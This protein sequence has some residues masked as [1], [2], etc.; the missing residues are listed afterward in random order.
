MRI[1]PTGKILGANIEDIDLSQPLS[2]QR[3]QADPARARRARRPLLPEAASGGGGLRPLRRH[4]RRARDQRRQ[5]VPRAGP[6]AGHG[7]LQH[8]QGRQAGRARRCRP[9]LAHRHVLF[10]RTS[11][12]PTCSTPSRCRCA[13]AGRSATPSSATCTRPTR[14]C[15]PTSSAACA[16]KHRHPRL[17]QVLGHD[18]RAPGLA[19]R[20]ADARAAR[21]EAAG[22]AADLPA[23]T[24]SPAATSSTAT[25]A[26]RCASTACRKP[27][28]T[29]CSSFLSR[30]RK[31]RSISTPI[32][33]PRATC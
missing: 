8:D 24:P 3:L 1:A 4:V 16:G 26:T 7:P 15:P 28:V 6:P 25:P 13:T 22:V 30:I 14:T 31:R 2:D 29:S 20:T 21:Q 10:A 5:P 27:R 33:G 9:G 18:A 11:P 12:S 23:R 19:A 17:R 32:A